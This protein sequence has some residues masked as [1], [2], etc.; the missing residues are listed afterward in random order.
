MTTGNKYQRTQEQIREFWQA[1]P[2]GESCVGG[3]D[4]R[5]DESLGKFFEKYDNFR[6]SECPQILRNLAAI[7]PRGKRVLEIGLGQGA[8][9]EQLIRRGAK[10]SGLELT[11]ESAQRVAKRLSLHDL[12]HEA[13]VQGSA[14]AIP[15]A[16]DCFD[17]VFSYGVL[18]HVPD[19]A[20]AQREIARVLKP[21]GELVAM[22]YAKWSL[23]YLLSIAVL[24]R[25]GLL[26]MWHLHINASGKLSKHVENAR[27]QGIWTYLQMKNFVHANTDGPSNPYSKVYDVREVRRVFTDFKVKKAYKVFMHA[28]PLPARLIH[29]LPGERMLGW[30]LWVHLTPTK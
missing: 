4:G 30:A 15:F 13:L 25:L 10:W 2:C 24:R 22:L 9:S 17:I 27:R 18:H 19:I 7:Q 11:E 8:D 29:V 26:A 23:N 16:S 5:D 14:L 3:L 1:H 20:L 21:G 6:Y 12:R 28:P